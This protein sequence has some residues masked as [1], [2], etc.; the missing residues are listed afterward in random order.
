[1]TPKPEPQRDFTE[2]ELRRMDATWKSDFD[3]KLDAMNTRLLTI[4]RLV[5]TAV[6]G[7]AVVAAIATIG[8]NMVMK[9]GEKVDAVAL[10]Q[11]AAIAERTA[12]LESMKTDI[13]RLRDKK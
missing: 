3:L 2:A 10:R 4:E 11:A 7:T 12:I 6:G 1:M 13:N 8:I 9:Q 5:W